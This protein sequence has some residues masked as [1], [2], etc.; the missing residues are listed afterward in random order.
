[1]DRSALPGVLKNTLGKQALAPGSVG[2]DNTES[3]PCLV[4]NWALSKGNSGS[5]KMYIDLWYVEGN[6][7]KK[8]PG[9]SQVLG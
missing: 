5:M 8:E 6:L 9:Y 4:S 2:K 1:M 3:Q 7:V